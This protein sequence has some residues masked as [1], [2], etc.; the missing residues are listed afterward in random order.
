MGYRQ[1]TLV[2]LRFLQG[3]PSGNRGDRRANLE[4][5]AVSPGN[6]VRTGLFNVEYPAPR[7]R[8][9][10]ATF[11]MFTSAGRTGALCGRT[12]RALCSVS[13][14]FSRCWSDSCP[15]SAPWRHA[16]C[17][18]FVAASPAAVNPRPST[19]ASA[20]VRIFIF[21]VY[22]AIRVNH[23]YIFRKLSAVMPDKPTRPP[24]TAS[25]PGLLRSAACPASVRHAEARDAG[26]RCA[27][28][29]RCPA[30]S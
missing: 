4:A 5:F 17:S 28:P 30:A 10:D 25:P 16:I 27:P 3:D 9:V 1:G 14:L 18:T 23:K 15:S 26:R 29:C 7:Q 6:D 20:K 11:A 2:F 12:W 13:R 19:S 22:C 24:A 21:L 8:A